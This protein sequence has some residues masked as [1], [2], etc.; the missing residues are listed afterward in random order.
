MEKKTISS[1][2][3]VNLKKANEA[4]TSCISQ[5]FLSK[6]LGG[7]NVKVE[8]FCIKERKSMMDLDHMIYGKLPF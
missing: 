4:Y 1:G 8:D 5:E 6:F 7:E 3:K 2:D